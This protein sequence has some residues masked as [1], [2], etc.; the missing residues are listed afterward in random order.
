[1]SLRYEFFQVDYPKLINSTVMFS[2]SEHAS[3]DLKIVLDGLDFFY[4]YWIF[5][6]TNVDMIN[7]YAAFMVLELNN[8]THAIIENCTFGYWIFQNVPYA[9]IRNC[10][11]RFEEGASTAIK[12]MNSSA[13]V[14]NMTMKDENIT[15]DYNGIFVYYYSLLRIE[16]SKFV[17]NTVTRGII[18]IVKTSSLIMS[19]CI[20]SG[21]YATKYPGVIYA[22]E[23]FVYLKNTYFKGNTA[24][25]LGGAIFIEKMSYLRIKNCIFKQNQVHGAVGSG[26]AIFSLYNSVLDVSYSIFDHNKAPYRGALFQ[27][28]GKTIIN[29]CLFFGNSESVIAS[30]NSSEISIMN[31]IFQNNSANHLGGAVAVAEKSVL[32]ISNT[33]FENNAQVSVSTKNVHKPFI[34]P[35]GGGAIYLFKSVGNISNSRFYNNSASY[36]GGSVYATSNCSLSISNTTFENNVAV[37][38]GGTITSVNCFMNIQHTKFKNNSVLNKVDGKGGGLYLPF[39]STIEISHTLFSKCHASIGGAIT[40]NSSTII[41]FN[42]SVIANTGSAVVLGKGD[43]FEIKNSSFYNNSTPKDGGAII[44]DACV[45]QMTNTRFSYNRAVRRGGAVNVDDSK[46]IAHSCLFTDNDAYTGGAMDIMYSNVSI[47]DSTF[48]NNTAT[49]GGI[50]RLEEAYLVMTNNHLSNNTAHG[51]GGVILAASVTMLMSN[52]LVINN[53]ANGNGAVF[54]ME[55]GTTVLRNSSFV[56]N[57]ARLRGGILFAF[58]VAVIHIVQS[59]CFENQ[60]KYS[61]GVLSTEWQTTILV[62]DTTI[63]T[64]SADQCGVFRIEGNSILELNGSLVE[65][66]NAKIG[67][68]ALCLANNSLFIAV[69]SSFNGNTAYRDSIIHLQNST[70]YLEKCDFVENQI[71]YFGGTI[72]T[73]LGTKLKI[74]DTVFTQNEGYDLFYVVEKNR[75]M[76]KFEIYKSLFVRG[77]ISL[78]SNVTNFEEVAVEEKLI[79]Q[80]PPLNQ[81][82]LKPQETPYASSK[83]PYLL[84]IFIY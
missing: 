75:F 80:W 4:S 59:F 13:F 53:T 24:F 5:F 35:Q 77:N 36:A 42:S 73:V 78:N 7:C 68:G 32:Y 74:S 45:L 70:V 65:N 52:C 8:L 15:T 46:L 26:A 49:D 47:F 83:L 28:T 30:W 50:A 79:G 22:H 43:S 81:S 9:S 10:N 84:K 1:M 64:N 51:D 23:S 72:V 55:G 56:T 62:S 34:L 6:G 66:N 48:S 38:F 21:N 2:T 17:N 25:L 33:T 60:A 3:T 61:S 57:V 37:A 44:C 11:N 27:L 63:S 20:V 67:A 31:S 18:K 58:R 12:F 16:Q 54:F 19:K 76:F 41:M 14:E 69:N 71:T 29:Q 40:S 82:L 39:N